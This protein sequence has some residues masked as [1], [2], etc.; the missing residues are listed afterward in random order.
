MAALSDPGNY[1]PAA[2]PQPT[3]NERV[4]LDATLRATDVVLVSPLYWYSVSA[5]V[6]LYLDYWGCW[7][8]IP[9]VGFRSR[10]RGKVMWSVTATADDPEKAGPLVESLKLSAEYLGMKWGGEVVGR[11][12]RPGDVHAEAATIERAKMLFQGTRR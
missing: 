8:H 6:K 3:G 5:S 2:G 7:L 9:Q 10:M 4:L 12:C 1:A 11:S